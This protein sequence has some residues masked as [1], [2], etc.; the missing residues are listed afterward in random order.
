MTSLSDALADSAA[1]V[2][3]FLDQLLAV[4][5]ATEHRLHEAMR[6]A[7]LEG[8]KRLRPFL[9]MQSA[10]LFGVG[11]RAA[12]RAGSALELIHCYSLVHDDL[13]AMDDDD[14]RRGK[15]T[16]HKQY[17]EATAILAGDA[18]LTLSFE[19][20]AGGDTHKDPQVRNDLV[21]ALA[22]RAGGPGMVGGQV[23]DLTSENAN[24]DVKLIARLATMKTG[25]LMAF[26]TAAGAILGEASP[27]IVNKLETFGFDLGLAFQITDDLLDVEGDE[28]DLGKKVGKDAEAGKATFVSALGVDGARRE[29]RQVAD[30]ALSRLD[31]F[32]G[33][34]DELRSAAAMMVRSTSAKRTNMTR[35]IVS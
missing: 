16:L 6:Y 31:A 8:G 18:L 23:I 19:I 29:A 9:V 21:Y 4:E 28:Y 35:W 22:T 26:S 11:E 10:S 32:G 25:A 34:A 3:K 1:Q 13:P 5:D 20:L 17:D 14:L 24:V 15:P 27:S 2:E 7:T 30:R 12:L 33:R